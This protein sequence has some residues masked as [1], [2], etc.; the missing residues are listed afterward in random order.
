MASSSGSLAGARI[1]QDAVKWD[2]D[3]IWVRRVSR[4]FWRRWATRWSA[5]LYGEEL[6]GGRLGTEELTGS[7]H[8]RYDPRQRGQV[9]LLATQQSSQLPHEPVDRPPDRCVPDVDPV[10]SQCRRTPEQARALPEI[11]PRVVDP[12]SA[13]T[14]RY[15]PRVPRRYPHLPSARAMGRVDSSGGDHSNR[16]QWIRHVRH[17]S[18]DRG[19][20][21]AKQEDPGQCGD[22]RSGPSSKQLFPQPAGA[23]GERGQASRIRHV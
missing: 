23:G 15:S 1:Q 9:R 8:R 17:A 20:H 7:C 22:E 13:D 10:H 16:G 11:P 21:R 3:T 6:G 12:L 14:D 5:R 2:S 18:A 19:S 4:G